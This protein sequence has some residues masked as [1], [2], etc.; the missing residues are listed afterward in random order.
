MPS[1]FNFEPI[2]ESSCVLEIVLLQMPKIIK[3]R[4]RFE[5]IIFHTTMKGTI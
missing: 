1:D 3:G 2:L 5:V 4:L